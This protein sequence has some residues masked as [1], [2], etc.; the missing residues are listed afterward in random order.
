VRVAANGIELEYESIGRADDPAMILVAGLGAQ[1]IDWSL[2]FCQ[3]LA[4][5][6]FRVI[7]FD[8]RDAGLSTACDD[9][10]AAPYGITDLAA[11]AI[12]LL[13]AL[14]V[15][16]A[17]LVGASMGGMIVQ[18]AAVEH[19][20]RVLSLCSIMSTTGNPDVG[21]PTPEV[22]AAR[23]VPPDG[24]RDAIIAQYVRDARRLSSPGFAPPTDDEL[25]ERFAAK[26]DRSY[27]PAGRLRQAAAIARAD[28]RTQALGRI[29]APTLVVH[30]SADPLIGVSGGY[31]TA[32]AIPGADLLVIGGMGHAQPRGAIPRLVA[33]IVA[34]ARRPPES[35]H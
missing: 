2:E 32:A 31:A 3:A 34:N 1:L 20:D 21:Q 10:D 11:D 19:P 16:R 15:E 28:D 29:T 22:A 25:H 23:R 27:R 4:D 26:Y 8:N 5:H 18:Q 6:G 30:G 24:P 7:R 13:D 12:G 14:G 17:H 9:T 35:A 33:A